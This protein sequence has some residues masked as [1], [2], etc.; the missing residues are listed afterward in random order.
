MKKNINKTEIMELYRRNP[1]RGFEMIYKEYSGQIFRYLLGA[2]RLSS[3]EAEDVLHNIFLPWVKNPEKI[4]AVE[5]L[6]SYLYTCARNAAIKLRKNGQ[7]NFSVPEVSTASH[8]AEVENN[9]LISNA[10]GELPDNQK[11]VVVLK[12]WSN[13]TFEEIAKLLDLNLQ[14]IAS[15]YRYA[16]T[17]LKGLI[18]WEK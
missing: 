11:E 16:I 12:V 17:K 5:N 8:D 2:F 7:D 10:L 18:P 4:G 9:L 15:R 1:Q 14:T 6:S 3:E 13:M